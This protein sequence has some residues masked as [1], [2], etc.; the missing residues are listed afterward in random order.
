MANKVNGGRRR[1][2][3]EEENIYKEAKTDNGEEVKMADKA[4]GEDDR[5]TEREARKGEGGKC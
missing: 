2:D 3:Q 4:M 5:K 1:A